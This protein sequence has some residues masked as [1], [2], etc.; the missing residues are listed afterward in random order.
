M[1]ECKYIIIFI[2]RYM[3][4]SS[5]Y[6]N[7]ELHKF[8]LGMFELQIGKEHTNVFCEQQFS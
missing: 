1:Q 5:K 2:L 6:L 3:H 8:E 7:L 4:M